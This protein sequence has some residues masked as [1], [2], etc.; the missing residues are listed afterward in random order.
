M[1]WTR[2]C[3]CLPLTESVMAGVQV[4]RIYREILSAF[5]RFC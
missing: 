3:V 1:S 4:L 2:K 5:S